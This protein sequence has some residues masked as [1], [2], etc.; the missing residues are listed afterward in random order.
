[1]LAGT[2]EARTPTSGFVNLYRCYDSY[3]SNMNFAP[4][5]MGVAASD[6]TSLPTKHCA[7]GI[8]VNTFFPTYV[9]LPSLIFYHS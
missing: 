3:D 4:N 6:T 9:F 5:P 8:R 1:M 2:A 7:G